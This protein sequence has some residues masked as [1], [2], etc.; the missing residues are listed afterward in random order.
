VN[1]L[2]CQAMHPVQKSNW[3]YKDKQAPRDLQ[4]QKKKICGICC[5]RVKNVALVKVVGWKLNVL[6][7]FWVIAI[8]GAIKEDNAL[9][10][11][12]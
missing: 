2:A 7:T 5:E 6:V 10:L 4:S 9:L 11:T 8:E 3:T 12:L 1:V